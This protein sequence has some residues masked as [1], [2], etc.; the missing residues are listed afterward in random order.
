MSLGRSPKQEDLYRSTRA[1]CEARL[2][3][4]SVFRLLA[5]DC[6]RLFPD[7]EFAD[8]FSEIGRD[9]VPPRVVAVVMVLQRIHGLSDRDAVDAFAFDVR[10]KYA[11][12][13]LDFD[14]PGFVHT[15]LVDMRGRLRQSARP[16]RIFEA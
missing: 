12:G 5:R 16:N 11:A 10:W 1:A 14:H 8:L 6:H 9:S 4:T 15:V 3:E 2:P 7:E 13:A